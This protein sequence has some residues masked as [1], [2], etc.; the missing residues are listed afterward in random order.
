MKIKFCLNNNFLIYLYFVL[1]VL[2]FYL[3]LIYYLSTTCLL[4]LT[5]GV[6]VIHKASKLKVTPFEKLMNSYCPLVT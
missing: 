5:K 2:V 3:L 1:R 4:I 6:C